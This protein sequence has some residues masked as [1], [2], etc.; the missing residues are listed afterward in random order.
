MLGERPSSFVL[1]SKQLQTPAY[2]PSISS[3]KT[4]LR[5]L[6]Y[7]SVLSTS[8][9][10]SDKYLASAFDLLPLKDGSDAR[11]CIDAARESGCVV[12]HGLR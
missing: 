6:D 5:P 12:L 1:G 11:L 7:L 3:V 9:G 10:L 8:R 2:F 4:S